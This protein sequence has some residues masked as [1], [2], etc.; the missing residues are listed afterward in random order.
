M[1]NLDRCFN[2]FDLREAA[3]HR[4]PKGIFEYVDKGTEDQISLA[5]NRE[6]FQRI[7]LRT[8]FLNDWSKRDLGT[9]IFGNRI[10][11]PLGIA[12]TG[13][14]GLMWYRGEVELAKAAAAAGIPFTLAMGALTSLEEITKAVPDSRKWFQ[15]YPWADEAA[16]YEMVTRARDLGWETLVITIDH[17]PGRAR[18]HNERNGYS[19]PFKPNITA[20][21]DMA[22]HPGWL[23]RVMRKYLMNEGMPTNANYPDRYRH[24]V[25]DGKKRVSPQRFQAMTWEHI[26]K[27]RDFWPRKL[28]VKSILS[29]DQARAAVD[30]GA[31]GVVVSNHGGRAFDSAVA[32]IDILPEVVEAVGDR[33]TVILD[34]GIRRGSDIVKA[35]ALGA[36]MVLVGRATLYGTACGGQAG[37][38]RA[39]K[40]LRDEMERTF[41][42]VGARSVAE[43]GPHIFARNVPGA[44]GPAMANAEALRLRVTSL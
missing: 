21:V 6:A 41:G 16:N 2:I 40:I 25:I 37:A 36:K 38:A 34:S 4:L 32:T 27:F 20:A 12:P 31:D 39:I 14:A 29:G 22:R 24:S 42:Y 17:A 15:V 35:L 26:R 44:A 7:K 9:E 19:F 18:E 8:R 23:W 33:C 3:Q 43:I 11:L 10:E 13:S 30:A 5:E 1:T 28:I